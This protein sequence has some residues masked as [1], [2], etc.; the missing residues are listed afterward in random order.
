MTET[1]GAV[2][3]PPDF[4]YID[5]YNGGKPCHD[6]NDYFTI[7][8]PRMNVGHRAKIF[9]PFDALSGLNEAF[10]EKD[11]PCEDRLEHIPYEELP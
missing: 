6:E 9:S 11:V 1:V 2:P 7:M 4:P 10:A 8:H 5:V 3:V